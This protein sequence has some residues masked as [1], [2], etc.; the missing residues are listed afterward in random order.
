MEELRLSIRMD[1]YGVP[2]QTLRGVE[3]NMQPNTDLVLV[4]EAIV[5]V[6]QAP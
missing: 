1:L 2:E 5:K 3:N 4:A 6:V